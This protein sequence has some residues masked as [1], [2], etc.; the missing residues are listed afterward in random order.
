[1]GTFSAQVNSTSCSLCLNGTYQTAT[2]STSCF[3]CNQYGSRILCSRGIT[4][5]VTHTKQQ[6]DIL[7]YVIGVSAA[8]AVIFVS[9]A[10][11]CK[12]NK[13]HCF[14]TSYKRASRLNLVLESENTNLDS[15][16]LQISQPNEVLEISQYPVSDLHFNSDELKGIS[17]QLVFYTGPH[18]QLVELEI[19]HPGTSTIS[20]EKQLV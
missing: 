20:T 11:W 1:M 10:L 13:A 18:N 9:V 7:S 16:D 5:T 8:A 19:E 2:G 12:K 17:A 14:S 6:S 4:D 3:I 15:S